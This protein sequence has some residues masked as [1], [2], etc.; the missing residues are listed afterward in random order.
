MKIAMINDY[1]YGRSKFGASYFK[2]ILCDNIPNC[3]PIEFGKN[4]LDVFEEINE[5]NPDVLINTA[6]FGFVFP[7]HFTIT[8]VHSPYIAMD[9]LFDN[10]LGEVIKKQKTSLKKSNIRVAVSNFMAELYEECGKFEIIP[11]GINPEIFRPMNNKGELRIKYN[12]PDRE[13]GIFVGSHHPVKGLKE[14]MEEVKNNPDIFWILILTD[15]ADKETDNV[16]VVYPRV[17]KETL[18]ELYNCADF[19]ISKSKVESLHNACTEAMFC[20]IPV[21]HTNQGVFWDWIPDMKNPRKEAF[22]KGLDF[23]TVLKKWNNL[24]NDIGK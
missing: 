9:K 22:K 11:T 2:G 21:K 1:I 13:V 24:I 4:K 6:I 19:L 5:L 15:Y 3:I 17:S 10:D 18:A 8:T 16:K 7:K 12:I 14:V 23:E 20:N